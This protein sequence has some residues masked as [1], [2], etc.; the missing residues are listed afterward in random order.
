MT[1][2]PGAHVELNGVTYNL[3]ENPDMY[4]GIP[5]TW[6]PYEESVEPRIVQ[7]ADLA[8]SSRPSKTTRPDILTWIQ[9]DWSKGEG[10]KQLDSSQSDNFRGYYFGDG[11]DVRTKGQLTLGYQVTD[12]TAGLGNITRPGP[13]LAIANGYLG[14]AASD[15]VGSVNRS[16][17]K[18]LSTGTWDAWTTGMATT[19]QVAGPIKAYGN[20]VFVA[21]RSTGARMRRADISANTSVLMV[22]QV[23]ETPLPAGG[24]LFYFFDMTDANGGKLELRSVTLNYAGSALASTVEYAV[25]GVGQECSMDNLGKKIYFSSAGVDEEPRIHVF[26]IGGSGAERVRMPAGFRQSTSPH[27]TLVFL[28]DILFVGGWLDGGVTGTDVAML[29][30]VSGNHSGTVGLI[31]ADR[32]TETERILGMAGG[33][34][35]QLVIGTSLGR[36]YVYDVQNGGLSRLFSGFVAGDDITSIV[37]A[38]G[39]YYFGAR[40]NNSGAQAAKVYKTALSG[41]NRYPGSGALRSSTWDFGHPDSQ[42]LLWELEVITEPLA[43][44]TS[45]S[46]SILLDD[47]TTIT[48]DKEGAPL[49]HS[50][51]LAKSKVF[52][53]SGV[54]AAGA[55][56]SR[57]AR[58]VS[59]TT[60]MNSGVSG[61][62]APKI[63]KI[64]FR[65][66]STEFERFFDMTLDLSGDTQGT[67]DA[68]YNQTAE[69]KA[70]NLRALRDTNPS[71][72]VKFRPRYASGDDTRLPESDPTVYTAVMEDCHIILTRKG[73]GFARVRVRRIT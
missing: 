30:Y 42:K 29:C 48:T 1:A 20:Y 53:L 38:K 73:E 2:S 25:A 31:G 50:T 46:F 65:A 67:R 17:R 44:G 24:K 13:Y 7:Q 49:T 32:N 26:E 6:R 54:D 51:A 59:V 28:G 47:D 58:Q 3:A 37:Y 35:N 56:I 40:V 9:D 68:P 61:A 71:P 36:G 34:R 45:V 63:T 27:E 5:Y 72:P 64:I 21:G 11:V 66:L 69:Q 15:T 18:N 43:T 16:R 8:G 60:T 22:D 70:D 10:F 55:S 19:G 57:V 39:V 4:D 52:S 23:C 14:A 12:D 41:T 62:N 33:F